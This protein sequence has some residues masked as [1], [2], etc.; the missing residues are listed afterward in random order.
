MYRTQ[1][2]A[3]AAFGVHAGPYTG[4]RRTFALR[5]L[6]E[7]T[8]RRLADATHGRGSPTPILARAPG[9]AGWSSIGAG[10]AAAAGASVLAELVGSGFGD[11]ASHLAI[12]PPTYAAAYAACGA[13]LGASAARAA[14]AMRRRSHPIAPGT[15]VF[16]LD[17]VDVTSD[18]VSALPLGELRAVDVRRAGRR[19][20]D[21]LLRFSDG[22]VRDFRVET[23]DDAEAAHRLLERA[24]RTLELLT[25]HPD[26]AEAFASDVFYDL[27]ADGFAKAH[28]APPSAR[29]GARSVLL[30]AAIGASVAASALSIRNDASDDAMFARAAQ[31]SDAARG[32]EAYLAAGRRHA[33]EAR[34]LLDQLREQAAARDAAQTEA[35]LVPAAEL[36]PADVP[37]AQLTDAAR[38]ARHARHDV[39]VDAYRRRATIDYPGAVGRYAE[40]LGYAARA[41]DPVLRVR[42]ERAKAAEAAADLRVTA[43]PDMEPLSE[44]ALRRREDVVITT[45]RTVLSEVCPASVL[46]V[47]REASPAPP[48][49]PLLSV[50]YTVDT[51]RGT[52][53]LAGYAAVEIV[54]DVA[55]R[56]GD[57]KEA[58]SFRLT[59]PPPAA[60]S[61]TVRDSS[62]Y[63]IASWPLPLVGPGDPRVYQSMTAR[64]FDRLFDELYSLFLAGDPRVP[65]GPPDPF[66]AP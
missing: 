13:V 45:L 26:M 11:A 2:S 53:A 32:Y 10:I 41:G 24:Q 66:E 60:L 46:D 1:G 58:P 63:R 7:E 39:C 48:R 50:A 18:A 47:V 61:V 17:L 57:A 43:R 6:P 56:T 30:G 64:A 37:D 59:M 16:P 21:V 35:A 23:R 27:R 3:A 52:G 19:A 36:P 28:G 4:P 8:V 5:D 9:R 55:L 29:R 12:E 54:F 40:I 49:A 14:R 62:L 65:V 42:F 20:C 25:V 31:T 22:T 38:A 51:P 33:G 34:G 15:Y 44:A